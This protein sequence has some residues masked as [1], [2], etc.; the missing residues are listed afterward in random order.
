MTCQQCNWIDGYLVLH[1]DWGVHVCHGTILDEHHVC[2]GMGWNLQCNSCRLGQLGRWCHTASC[3]L[4]VVPHLLGHRQQR[5]QKGL[6]RCLCIVPAI[7][8]LVTAY[9][10]YH[11]T[12]NSPRGN[13]AKLKTQNQMAQVNLSKSFKEG[14][15]NFQHVASL[16]PIC[17]LFWC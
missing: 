6:E 14:M 3:G 13:F 16:Y 12:D 7:L 2:E 15:C 4:H 11:F 8:G 9:C 1:W 10:V 5:C 17:L